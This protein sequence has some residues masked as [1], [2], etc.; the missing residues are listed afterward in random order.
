[1]K[2]KILE[3]L[4][5]ML[6]DKM[7][8]LNNRMDLLVYENVQL[9][10]ASDKLKDRLDKNENVARSAMEKSSMNE[11]HSRKNNIK[12]IGV[13]EEGDATEE[14]LIEKI[15]NILNAKTS[16]TIN[17]NKIVAIHLIPGKTGMPKPVLMKLM[18]NN[19]KTKIM[20]KRKLVKLAGF[21]LVDDVTKQNTKL[22]NRLNLHADIDS[23]WYF[24]GNVFAKTTKGNAL[25]LTYS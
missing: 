22:I 13:V 24:N 18:I 7:T 15:H 3:K 19:E 11:Q 5:E 14:R 10:K 23:A 6:N 25:D 16:F 1:M 17:E 8:E 21:R 4:E 12:I 9:K 2:E 20:K